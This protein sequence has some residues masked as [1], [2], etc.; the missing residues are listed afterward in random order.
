MDERVAA[1]DEK[2]RRVGV[3]LGWV[4]VSSVIYLV[5]LIAVMSQLRTPL[6]SWT[7]ALFWPL[8]LFVVAIGVL[9]YRRT[10]L[11][12]DAALAQA[13]AT[14]RSLDALEEELDRSRTIGRGTGDDRHA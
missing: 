2:A 9:R 4:A 13:Q 6:P 7:P 11:K 14:S 8:P 1:I 10:W 5:L 12:G 3:A